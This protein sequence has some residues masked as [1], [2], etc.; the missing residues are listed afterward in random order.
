MKYYSDLI[1]KILCYWSY[2]LENSYKFLQ[3]SIV[4]K[5]NL[6]A[7]KILYQG[8]N[9]QRWIFGRANNHLRIIWVASVVNVYSC[10]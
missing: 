4:S 7:A 2:H 10:C 1:I 8:D 3:F 6:V 5:F 9:H